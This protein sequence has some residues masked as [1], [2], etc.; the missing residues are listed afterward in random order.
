MK[1]I[2][3][4]IAVAFAAMWIN[5]CATSNKATN[6]NNDKEV[7]KEAKAYFKEK[8]REGFYAIGT[9][10]Q[11]TLF[12]NYLNAKKAVNPSIEFDAAAVGTERVASHKAEA[13]VLAK[14]AAFI[15][16]TNIKSRAVSE[17]GEINGE[18][19]DT[20]YSAYETKVRSVVTPSSLRWLKLSKELNPNSYRYEIYAFEDPSAHTKRVNALLEAA[21]ESGLAQEYAERVSDW[22]DAGG[23]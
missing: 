23:E 19:F 16:P 13:D 5:S 7:V 9:G 18:T 17:I 14:Y 2:F 8:A 11:Y 20:F 12:Y 22:I 15:M 21:E 6:V 3:A 4:V 10:D 1:K